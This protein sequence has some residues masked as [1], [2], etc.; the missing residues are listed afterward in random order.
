MKYPH[1]RADFRGAI[2]K[3]VVVFCF[4]GRRSVFDPE[5]RVRKNNLIDVGE[6]RR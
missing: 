2:A 4:F 1:I 6:E 5:L 3:L